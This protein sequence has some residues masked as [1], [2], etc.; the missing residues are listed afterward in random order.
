[1]NNNKKAG[2][3]TLALGLIF[4]GVVLLIANVAGTGVLAAAL[5]YWPVLLIGLGVEYFA[6]KPIVVKTGITKLKIDNL[7][8]KID[9]VPSQDDK[10]YVKARIVGWGPSEKEARRR[11]EM[12]GIN[13]S[14][15][16]VVNINPGI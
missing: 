11:A 2:P 10:L 9:L 6:S 14:E 5:K 4:F 16:D 13:I 7:N 8:G 3:V 15:G 12:V 1:V